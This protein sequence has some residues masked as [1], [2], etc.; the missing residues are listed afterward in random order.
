MLA[1]DMYGS[2]K[3]VALGNIFEYRPQPNAEVP[4]RRVFDLTR[5]P[6]I[7]SWGS[8]CL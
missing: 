1:R 6:Q 8:A 7:Y 4:S 2:M 5:V 3:Q